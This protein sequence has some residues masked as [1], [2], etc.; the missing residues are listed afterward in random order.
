MGAISPREDQLQ[1]FLSGPEDGPITMINL[2]RFRERADYGEGSGEAPC[3][4]SEAYGR[5]SAAVAPLLAKAGGRPVWVGLGRATL[6]A[7]E[8][9]VW[10]QAILVAYLSR[11]AFLAMT[12]SPEYRA[13]AHHRT[14]ALADSRLIATSGTALPAPEA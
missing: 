5:Y 1:G 3:S 2:L 11:Q 4:G 10:D 13:I 8:G 14:A 9:E 12:T 7:P 6:I